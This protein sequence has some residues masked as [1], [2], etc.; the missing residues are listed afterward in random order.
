MN[1]VEKVMMQ[2][3]VVDTFPI[4]DG[5]NEGREGVILSGSPAGMNAMFLSYKSDSESYSVGS[6]TRLLQIPF[7]VRT[8][9]GATKIMMP[10]HLVGIGPGPLI[11]IA[12]GMRKTYLT[13][14]Y[15][16]L[17][18]RARGQEK[19]NYESAAIFADPVLV[20]IYSAYKSISGSSIHEALVE[21]DYQYER[22]NVYTRF[23]DDA[24]NI[25]Y[26]TPR[27]LNYY[28][29]IRTVRVAWSV[30]GTPK[31]VVRHNDPSGETLVHIKSQPYR[32]QIQRVYQNEGWMSLRDAMQNDPQLHAFVKQ[33]YAN[34]YGVSGSRL[35]AEV[36]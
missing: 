9:S 3:S 18:Y 27:T 13:H 25:I 33:F 22:L 29:D 21:N 19:K 15:N 8:G 17:L 4:Q 2:L 24:E 12:E 36:V 10:D 5:V 20:L 31:D 14:L 35:P 11:R 7:S 30:G 23:H 28:P 1:H 16:R 32:L 34:G 26:N 6:D